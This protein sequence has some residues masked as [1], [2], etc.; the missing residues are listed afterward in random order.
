VTMGDYSRELCGGTHVQ[1]TGDIGG[2]KIVSEGSVAAGVRRIEA[3]SGRALVEYVQQLEHERRELAGLL[4]VS[5][6]DVAARVQRLTEQVKNLERDA[7]Q[8]KV[9]AVGDADLMA[10]MQEVNGVKVLACAVDGVDPK[11]LRE[12]GDRY[13][14]KLGSGIVALGTVDGEKATVIVMVTKDLSST[15]KAGEL[16]Q[17]ITNALGGKGGGRPDM[18]QGGGPNVGALADALETLVMSLRS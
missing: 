13:K 7:R 17:S 5:P 9:N 15:Y 12:I 4:K 1:A 14:Q 18:A 2:C 11:A 16:I 6:Q 8:A 10:Q 3:L